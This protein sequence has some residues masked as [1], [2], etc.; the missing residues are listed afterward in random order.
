M[1]KSRD[2]SII[3]KVDALRIE[4]NMLKKDIA[5]ISRWNQKLVDTKFWQFELQKLQKKKDSLKSSVKTVKQL[6]AD[7]GTDSDSDYEEPTLITETVGGG[8]AS[9]VEKEKPQEPEE[10]S[11]EEEEIDI[12]KEI[13]KEMVQKGRQNKVRY[14]S[15]KEVVEALKQSIMKDFH[16]ER[17]GRP[18]EKPEEVK[19]EIKQE[20]KPESKL[21]VIKEAKEEMVK[22]ALTVPRSR[23][24]S[25]FQQR[26]RYQ[27]MNKSIFSLVKSQF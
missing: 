18:R 7:S 13:E 8:V 14:G 25:P 24:L 12:E 21:A 16:I 3:D 10:E 6:F 2:R 11:E 23:S 19:Q 15:Q 26:Q 27:Q 17:R 4:L 5:P 20:I 22:E 9:D 1:P